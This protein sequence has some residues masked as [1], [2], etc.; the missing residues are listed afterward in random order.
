MPL[1]AISLQRHFV[2][3]LYVIERGNVCVCVHTF[4]IMYLKFVSI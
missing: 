3:E 2:F 4:V 1:L